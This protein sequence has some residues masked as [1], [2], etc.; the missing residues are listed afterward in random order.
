MSAAS[1]RGT[2]LIRREH[3]HSSLAMTSD[4]SSH[5]CHRPHPRPPPPP[6]PITGQ[7][8]IQIAIRRVCVHSRAARDVLSQIDMRVEILSRPAS[9]HVHRPRI[10]SVNDGRRRRHSDGRRKADERASSPAVGAAWLPLQRLSARSRHTQVQNNGAS[11][12]MPQTST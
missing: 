1:S 6:A 8:V 7:S 4:L 12:S 3:S 9:V 10:Q 2:R 11:R 5:A